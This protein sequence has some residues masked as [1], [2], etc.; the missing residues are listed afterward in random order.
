[1]IVVSTWPYHAS[2][3]TINWECYA[4]FIVNPVLHVR[5]FKF[6]RPGMGSSFL[7]NS[8]KETMIVHSAIC[9][10]REAT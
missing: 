3:T 9:I 10:V 1:M 8:I 6:C 7:F 2:A 5:Y 4:Y